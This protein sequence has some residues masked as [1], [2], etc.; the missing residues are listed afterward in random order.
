MR[1]THDSY[2]LQ[3]LSVLADVAMLWRKSASLG[4]VR[5]AQSSPLNFFSPDELNSFFVRISRAS[6]TCDTADFERA[7]NVPLTSAYFL[8]LHH[9]F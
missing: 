5:P 4:L 9:L 8:F 7:L 3:R 1:L 6:P 2:H